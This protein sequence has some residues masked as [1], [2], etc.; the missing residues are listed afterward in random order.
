MIR[1]QSNSR[2]PPPPVV[3]EYDGHDDYRASFA[4]K[5]LMERV[6]GAFTV[7]IVLA[8][9]FAAGAISSR[10]LIGD[11]KRAAEIFILGALGWL[12]VGPVV[13]IG[14]AVLISLEGVRARPAVWLT[15]V[16]LA[17]GLTLIGLRYW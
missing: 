11:A 6:Q 9:W 7:A 2:P 13:A 16:A 1:R 10:L 4:P 5:P 15:F 14:Y 3:S 12:I 8:V 17:A